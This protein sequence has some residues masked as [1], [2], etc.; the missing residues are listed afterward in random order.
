LLGAT[1]AACAPGGPGSTGAANGFLPFDSNA[2]R[3]DWWVAASDLPLDPQTKEIHG[4]L[5]ERACASGGSPEGRV[6]G[7]RIEY[8]AN[9][10]AVTFT[11]RSLG[12][13]TCPTNPRFP[14]TIQLAE[15]LRVRLLLDGGVDPPRDATV[16]PTIVLVPE[17]EDCGPLVDT[18]F[19]KVAC[20]ALENATV[21]DRYES[22]RTIRIAA[23][24]ADCPDH[25]CPDE[26]AVEARMWIVDGVERDGT[27][28]RWLCTYEDEVADCS[29]ATS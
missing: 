22:Y 15:P 7:P 19:G 17:D 12:T 8:R 13:A 3:A 6:T 24:G 2:G 4:F 10:V 9:A 28:H 21:G 26:A 23:A 1:L 14:V 18:D 25:A 11:V 29:L 20:L 16:D 5:Q 27:R